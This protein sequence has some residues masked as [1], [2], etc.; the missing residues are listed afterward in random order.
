[1]FELKQLRPRV[2]HLKFDSSRELSLA[3]VRYTEFYE[4]KY[5]HIRENKFTLVQQMGAYCREYL[6]DNNADWTYGSDW[7]GFNVPVSVIKQV[8]DLGILDFNHYDHIMIGVHDMIMCE[9]LN[10]SAYLIGTS[11]I[12]DSLL[13]HEMTHAMFYL[14]DVYRNACTK[15]INLVSDELLAALVDAMNKQN[16]PTK[17][18][19]DEIQAYITTGE[20]G[21]FDHIKE[22]KE[23]NVLRAKLRELHQKTYPVFF[24]QSKQKPKKKKILKKKKNRN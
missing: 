24:P 16:Y 6:K 11:S 15:L 23:L 10:K 21:F 1:M 20:A 12:N 19:I 13:H 5:D 4:S 7:G 22:Q 17:V 3:F 9:T 14:D 2:F 18:A 8:H